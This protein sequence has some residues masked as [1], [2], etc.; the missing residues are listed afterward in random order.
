MPIADPLAL[1][2]RAIANA[3]L[4]A[5]KDPVVKAVRGLKVRAAMAETRAKKAEQLLAERA[6]NR[7]SMDPPYV[8]DSA[9]LSVRRTK[10]GQTYVLNGVAFVLVETLFNRWKDGHDSILTVQ[11]TPDGTRGIYDAFI[12]P[13]TGDGRQAL[14]DLLIRTPGRIKL[15]VP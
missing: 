10:T 6:R 2:R 1:F 5:D 8:F 13:K 9:S 12:R 14:H 11:L 15:Q 3:R 4:P 7:R